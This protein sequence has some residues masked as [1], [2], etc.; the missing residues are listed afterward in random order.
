V[1]S[2]AAPI[3]EDESDDSE[4]DEDE[5]TENNDE[6]DPAASL[7]E[8]RMKVELAKSDRKVR[9]SRLSVGGPKL[10][11]A[12]GPLPVLPSQET[13]EADGSIDASSQKLSTSDRLNNGAGDAMDVD[14]SE[15]PTES[16][17]GDGHEALKQHKKTNGTSPKA[18]V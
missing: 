15:E 13:V 12:S 4:G 3:V 18:R 14:N 8:L 10:H 1:F 7:E 16:L 6:I 2:P 9:E 5:N 11:I 17:L